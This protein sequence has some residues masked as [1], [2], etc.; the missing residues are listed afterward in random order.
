MALIAGLVPVSASDNDE[1]NSEAVLRASVNV[2]T[3][4]ATVKDSSGRFVGGLKPQDFEVFD[5]DT[6]QAIEFFSEEDMPLTL[7]I[8]FD[9]SAS[10]KE[11]MQP[12]IKALQH[13]LDMSRKED[14]FFLITFNTTLNMAQDFT[15]SSAAIINALNEVNPCGLTALNDAI[16]AGI[17]KV[18][19][20]RNK[21]RALLLLSDGQ[22]NSSWY[23]SKELSNTLR[24]ADVQLYTVSI[25]QE[26]KKP[27]Q[28][29]FVERQGREI[30]K[31]FSDLS[32]GRAF[33]PENLS[34][35]EIMFANVNTELRHQYSLGFSPSMGLDGRWHRLRVVVKDDAR[36]RL[37]VRSRTGYQAR[38]R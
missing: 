25:A 12:S 23:S 26:G 28:L 30:L 17:E 35:L 18:K 15:Q 10:M 14:E 36:P 8:L 21:K 4:Y 33:F 1:V 38:L 27:Q 24:E 5:N 9:A 22:D 37:A 20:G 2:V 7:G 13:F 32:G 34:D 6:K 16:Y 19:Q 29:N 3:I 31:Q 11:R